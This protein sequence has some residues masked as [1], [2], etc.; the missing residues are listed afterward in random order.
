MIGLDTNVLVR[1]LTHDDP[2]QTAMARRLINH[3]LNELELGHVSVVTLVELIWVLRSSYEVQR[4]ELQAF[5]LQ[6][7]TDARLLIQHAE[8][9]WAAVDLF[10]RHNVDFTDAL[11]AALDRQQGCTHTVTFDRKATRVPGVVLLLN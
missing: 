4:D 9:V 8:A 11:I 6:L 1:Y 7:L 10:K 2:A 5:V 3:T